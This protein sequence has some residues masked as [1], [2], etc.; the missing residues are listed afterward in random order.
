M[1]FFFSGGTKAFEHAMQLFF[2]N[3][4]VESDFDTKGCTYTQKTFILLVFFLLEHSVLYLSVR[5]VAS[6]PQ[7]K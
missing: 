4:T 2:T 5:E 6:R 3:A 7:R 1:F